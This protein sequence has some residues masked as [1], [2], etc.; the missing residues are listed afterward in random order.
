MTSQRNEWRSIVTPRGVERCAKR[1][2]FGRRSALMLME[3]SERHPFRAAPQGI[4]RG[5]RMKSAFPTLQQLNARL[6]QQAIEMAS[7]RASLAIQLTR[8]AQMQAE[9]DALPQARKHRQSLRALLS[10]PRPHAGDA[11]PDPHKPMLNVTP[12]IRSLQ[13]E[14]TIV[15]ALACETGRDF[16]ATR[17]AD[18]GWLCRNVTL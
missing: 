4:I 9:L 3:L 11:K 14:A 8:I 17:A 7:L 5:Y 13:A 2:S 15:K 10:Q 1:C 16:V 12:L 18:R 6:Q